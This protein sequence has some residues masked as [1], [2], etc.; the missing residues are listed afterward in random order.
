MNPAT[1]LQVGCLLACLPASPDR[2]TK[3]LLFTKLGLH[4]QG[5]VKTR[6]ALLVRSPSPHGAP[7]PEAGKFHPQQPARFFV[8]FLWVAHPPLHLDFSPS[9]WFIVRLCPRL[10]GIKAVPDELT[11]RRSSLMPRPVF[12]RQG[13]SPAL[14]S[15]NMDLSAG[16]DGPD[17]K[18]VGPN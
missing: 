7:L 9:R 11:G 17:C 1:H 10:D 5:P 15:P 18:F 3:H 12:S 6:T 8:D 4:H 13:H 16:R 2:F 14:T